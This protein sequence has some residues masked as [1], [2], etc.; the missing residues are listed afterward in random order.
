MAVLTTT[1]SFSDGDT[2]T[3]AKLNNIIANTSINDDAVTTRTIKDDAVELAQMA[4]NSVDTGQLVADSVEN[5][6][7]N[8]M[9]PTKA[10]AIG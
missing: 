3:A 10:T 9:T 6:K 4:D 1:Q 5:S 8:D 2:V 7:L